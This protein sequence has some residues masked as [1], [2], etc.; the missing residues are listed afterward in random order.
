TSVAIKYYLKKRHTFGKMTMEIQDMEGNKIT[1]IAPGKSKGINIV[2][3]NYSMKPPKLAAAKTFAFGGFTSPRA[4]AGMYKAVMKKGKET[5]ETTFE[6][7]NDPKSFITDA[8]RKAQ[9]DTTRKLVNEQEDLAYMV[10]ELDEMVKKANSIKESGSKGAKVA[11][12]LI[13]ELTALKETLVVTTG[14]NYVGTAP[15]QL[16]EKMSSIY[17]DVAS[18]FEAPSKP[19]LDNIKLLTDR[20]NKAK[21]DFAKIKSKQYAK[22]SKYLEKNNLEAVKLKS[23]DE[24][25]D[26]KE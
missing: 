6:I 9:Y 22:L 23:R 21:E 24:F 7:K 13:D 16:R 10:Y 3:W 20:F 19:Q 17:A 5:Y 11:Q 25:I 15:P 8:E 26:A 12:P 14:D 2:R 18:N 4:K 1:E